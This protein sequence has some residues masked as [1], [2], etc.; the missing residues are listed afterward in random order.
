M[1][2]VPDDFTTVPL[3]RVPTQIRSREKVSRALAA[4]DDIASREGVEALTLTRVAAAAGLSVGALHQYLPD[5]DAIVT[6]LISRYHERIETAMDDVIARLAVETVEDPI[7]QVIGQI[8]AIYTQER[9]VRILRAASTQPGSAGRAHKD[10]MAK[11]VQ[12]LME[13]CGVTRCDHVSARTVFVAAD[14]LMHEA[15]GCA[16]GPNTALL[17]ELEVMVRAYIER[18]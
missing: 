18:P 13:V 12:Q 11:R 1:D 4:A 17:T 10:R 14:A 9:A 16:D 15:F 8:A 3:R 2:P 6:A 5:R 7:A